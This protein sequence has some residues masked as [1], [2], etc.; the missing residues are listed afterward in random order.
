MHRIAAALVLPATDDP[1]RRSPTDPPPPPQLAFRLAVHS[2][3]AFVHPTVRA[4]VSDGSRQ[5]AVFP[6]A[7]AQAASESEGA[8]P[9]AEL[10]YAELAR[11]QNVRGSSASCALPSGACSLT[12]C[13]HLC[14]LC[15]LCVRLWV[16]CRLMY[17]HQ[18]QLQVMHTVRQA[19]ADALM[20]SA[21]V[22]SLC[23]ATECEIR[24]LESRSDEAAARWF[25]G[26][27]LVSSML[28]L[29]YRCCQ[30]RASSCSILPW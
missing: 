1:S 25:M 16:C 12:P 10:D 9:D 4:P 3:A 7:A 23:R 28:R 11:V 5:V 13:P 8:D 15:L 17:V 22:V 30:V 26:K 2:L 21:A 6:V 19:A 27:S 29:L 20:S 14:L 24:V 18:S